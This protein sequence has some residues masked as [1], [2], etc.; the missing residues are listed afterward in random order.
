[1][2]MPIGHYIGPNRTVK[3]RVHSREN[4]IQGQIDNMEVALITFAIDSNGH[5]VIVEAEPKRNHKPNIKYV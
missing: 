4:T 5:T 2:S 3:R 1:M